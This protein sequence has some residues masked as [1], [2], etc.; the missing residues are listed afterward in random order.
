M[1]VSRLFDEKHMR[2]PRREDG[3]ESCGTLPCVEP[4]TKRLELTSHVTP[5][6]LRTFEYLI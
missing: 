3:R 1:S 4:G 6:R 5:T 2:E